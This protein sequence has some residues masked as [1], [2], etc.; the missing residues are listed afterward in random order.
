MTMKHWLVSAIG[1]IALSFVLM[2]AQAA[3]LGGLTEQGIATAAKDAAGVENVH[4]RRRHWHH[5][6]YGWRHRHRYYY[7]GYPYYYGRPYYGYGGPRIGI[8][9]PG[10]GFYVGPRRRYWW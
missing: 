9:G 6:R 1:A 2:P 5:R 8:W 3:P 4:W 10:F 7:G